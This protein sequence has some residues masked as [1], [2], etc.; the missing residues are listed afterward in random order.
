MLSG[1]SER[2]AMDARAST[3]ESLGNVVAVQSI[4]LKET[5]ESDPAPL[6]DSERMVRKLELDPG[7][8]TFAAGELGT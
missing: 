8:L 4:D 2:L 3:D 7:S 1:C 5:V 6:L